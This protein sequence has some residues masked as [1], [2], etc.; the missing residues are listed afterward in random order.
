[1]KHTAKS[2]HPHSYFALSVP[3]F[4]LLLLL[5]ACGST[6]TGSSGSPTPTA[7]A[8]KGL[9]KVAY[10]GSLVNIMEKSVKPAFQQAT[11]YTYQGEGKGSTALVNEIKGHLSSPDVFISAG[12]GSDKLLMGAA[13][14]NYVS[15][16]VNMA[17]TELVIG[18]SPQSKFVADFQAA[19]SGSKPWYQVLEE[20]G[21]RI[22][23]TDPLLDPKGVNTIYMAELAEKYYNQPNLKQQIFGADENSSQIFPEEELVARMGTGQLDAGIFYLN[24]I[25]TTN[26]PYISLPPQINMGDPTMATEYATAKYTNPKTGAVS[27]GAPVIY[28]ITI[29]STSKDMAGAIAFLNFMLSQ[30]GQTLLASTGTLSTPIKAFGD[31]SAIP[32]MLQQYI[33]GS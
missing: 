23:R 32:P 21:M 1:M 10:A 20:P 33:T 12:A 16:Y 14:G 13:N 8:N 31:T 17:R 29:P 5:S 7:P 9:V 27:S 4:I 2:A 15:W 30:Q 11:G 18:Y 24:E 6:T 22:G 28:T 25:K 26:I 19:A 3:L